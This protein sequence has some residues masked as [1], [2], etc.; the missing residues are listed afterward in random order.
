MVDLSCTSIYIVHES[1]FDRPYCFQLVERTLPCIATTYYL[2]APDSET[3]QEW[4]LAIRPLCVPHIKTRSPS[5]QLQP[6]EMR[7]LYLTFL[8][9]K[10]LPVKV[11]PHPF[12]II[13]LGAVKVCKT[14]VKCPPDPIYEEDFVL[15]DIPQDVECFTM[16]LY[17]K[18]KQ[19]KVSSLLSLV[20]SF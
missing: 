9:A 5:G 16:T 19:S 12:F 15:E 17:N 4:I 7:T 14:S 6:T 3:Y 18:G 20:H 8:E 13:S 1:L 10:R 2:C 11:C